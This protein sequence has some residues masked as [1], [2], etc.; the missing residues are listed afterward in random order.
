[1]ICVALQETSKLLGPGNLRYKKIS[2]CLSGM[3]ASFGNF[4]MVL[5]D[6]RSPRVY[7]FR[8]PTQIK[9]RPPASVRQ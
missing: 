7:R 4:F 8:S 1:M 6:F 3:A 2:D 5:A 9:L